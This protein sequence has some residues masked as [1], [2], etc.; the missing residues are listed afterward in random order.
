MSPYNEQMN[1]KIVKKSPSLQRV[2]EHISRTKPSTSLTSTCKLT[3]LQTGRPSNQNDLLRTTEGQP[4]LVTQVAG[5]FGA[6]WTKPLA[7]PDITD[8]LRPETPKYITI[9]ILRYD[10]RTGNVEMRRYSLKNKTPVIAKPAGTLRCASVL[11]VLR[12][13]SGR[14]TFPG[15][16]ILG[17]LLC[18]KNLKESPR[19]H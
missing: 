16:T 12:W 17:A 7:G 18:V 9:I 10:R 4:G 6:V 19:K 5:S 1:K 15:M 13:D 8:S 14:I 2:P 11:A 3:G